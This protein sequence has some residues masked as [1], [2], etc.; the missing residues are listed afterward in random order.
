MLRIV[1]TTGRRLMAMVRSMRV[2]IVVV[3][4]LLLLILR[5]LRT[6]VQLLTHIVV[7]VTC[8]G[9]KRAQGQ[10]ARARHHFQSHVGTSRLSRRR[11]SSIATAIVVVIAVVRGRGSYAVPAVK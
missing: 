1:L 10:C 2:I 11:G 4:V 9:M 3:M 8:G 7:A 6:L 5:P